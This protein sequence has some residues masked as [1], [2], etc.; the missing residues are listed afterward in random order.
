MIGA[1]VS[2][3]ASIMGGTAQA[4]S[5]KAQAAFHRRQAEVEREK[6]G[7]VAGRQRDYLFRLTGN[8][9][10]AITSSGFGANSG[11]AV[12]L[13]T[14]AAT[15]GELDANAILYGAELRSSNE[16]FKGRM[17]KSNARNAMFGGVMGAIAPVIKALP[18][19][20]PFG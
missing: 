9:I 14:D 12:D 15:E 3:A 18:I 10:T 20:G 17:A 13:V 16:I 5:C 2:G 4:N 11:S 7:Y 1:I 6:G 8:Q 19:K